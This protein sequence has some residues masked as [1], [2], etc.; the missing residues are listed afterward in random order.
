MCPIRC[1]G[2][3]FA[4]IESN[5]LSLRSSFAV[6]RSLG[7]SFVVFSTN[8]LSSGEISRRLALTVRLEMSATTPSEDKLDLCARIQLHAVRPAPQE[9]ALTHT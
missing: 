7:S 4:R 6:G 3:A 5:H 8:S 9:S 2:C 1:A